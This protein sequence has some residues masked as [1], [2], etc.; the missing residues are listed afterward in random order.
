M[1]P[2][3]EKI[4]ACIQCG[5]CSGSC[6][7][8]YAMDV[9]P[10]EL[11]AI[12]RAGDMET[13]LKSNAIWTCASCYACQTR[14]PALIKITDIIYAIKRTAMERKIYSKKFPVHSLADSFT[15]SMFMFGR[16]NEPR[17]MVYYFLKSGIWK[18]LSY[19]PLGLTMARKGRIE[20][21]ASKIKDIKGLRK[22]IRAAEK[23]DM[24]I[25]YEV[26][27]YIEKAV[28]YKAVG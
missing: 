23:L 4:K 25:E 11:I 14:C 15:K 8:S 21:R 26:K 20:Y 19:I 5:T 18:A 16:L 27:P 17:L 24:P 13:L 10:R 12:F 1:I 6:P 28:G 2:G 3:G 9:P 7:V 22:I